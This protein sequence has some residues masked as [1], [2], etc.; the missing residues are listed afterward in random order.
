M[1]NI[2]MKGL[3]S[4]GPRNAPTWFNSIGKKLSIKADMAIWEF[5][6][7]CFMF[8]NSTQVYPLCTGKEGF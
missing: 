2:A 1:E 3:M 7:K 4:S 6:V 8:L 5:M